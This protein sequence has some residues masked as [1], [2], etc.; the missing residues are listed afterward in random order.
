MMWTSVLLVTLS[1]GFTLSYEQNPLKRFHSHL[2]INQNKF[3][4]F[5]LRWKNDEIEAIRSKEPN[6]GKSLILAAR[7]KGDR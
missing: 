7:H 1:C 6:I 5:L 3:I 2:I 4:F